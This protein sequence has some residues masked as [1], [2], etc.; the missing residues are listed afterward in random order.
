[1]NELTNELLANIRGLTVELVD[2]EITDKDRK[3][4][5]LCIDVLKQIRADNLSDYPVIAFIEDLYG[6]IDLDV[7]VDFYTQNA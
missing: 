4:L 2:E 5:K 3:Y 6:G 1:M 7:Y